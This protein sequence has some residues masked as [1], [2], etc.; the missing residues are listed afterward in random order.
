MG[1]DDYVI[2]WAVRG[3]PGIYVKTISDT[4]RAAIIN[5]LV[6]ECRVLVRTYHSDDQIDAMWDQARAGASLD[7]TRV[8]IFAVA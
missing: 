8:K 7:A 5:W 2:G 1:Q 3:P 4:R 6:T